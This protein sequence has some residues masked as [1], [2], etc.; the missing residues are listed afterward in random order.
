MDL[1]LKSSNR[2]TLLC[3]QRLGEESGLVKFL[4]GRRPACL[5]DLAGQAEAGWLCLRAR[6]ADDFHPRDSLGKMQG[7]CCYVL[8]P[9]H[10]FLD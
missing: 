9:S 6:I 8:W 7:W 2:F 1:S 5:S 10:L 3:T 4:S